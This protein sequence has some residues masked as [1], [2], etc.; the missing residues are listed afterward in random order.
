MEKPTI[1]CLTPVKN[2]GWILDRF[3]QCTSLW[4]DHIIIADQSTDHSTEAIAAH[5]PKVQVLK[6]PSLAYDEAA[7][8][9]LMLEAARQI[10]VPRLLITLDADEVLTANFMTSPE[11]QTMLNVAPGTVIRFNWVNLMNDMKHYWLSPWD[12]AWG[13]MDDG[14]EP[15]GK[16][17]HSERTPAPPNAPNLVLRD[18]KVIHYA[19]ADRPRR[20]S[21]WRWYQ[22]FERIIHPERSPIELYRQY[23]EEDCLRPDQVQLL[24]NHWIQGYTEQGIDMTSTSREERLWWDQD[25]LDLIEKHGPNYFRR[26]NIWNVDWEEY[27]RELYGKEPNCSLRDPRNKLERWVHRWLQSSQGHYQPYKRTLDIRI[28]EKVLGLLGW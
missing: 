21:K 7:R 4:A 19:Y 18:I 23:H 20:E 16:K 12:Y 1:I 2:E 17:L 6:N 5:Y 11:W 27:Y 10:P 26:Q 25:V 9:K 15:K 28:L 13:F 22:C 3:L 14:S 24:P 8:S